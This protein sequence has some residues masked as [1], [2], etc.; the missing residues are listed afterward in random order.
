[1]KRRI[2]CGLKCFSSCMGLHNCNLERRT[3][4]LKLGILMRLWKRCG[5]NYLSDGMQFLR[6]LILWI[7][8]PQNSRKGLMYLL[9]YIKPLYVVDGSDKLCVLFKSYCEVQ[10]VLSVTMSC[11]MVKFWFGPRVAFKLPEFIFVICWI[12]FIWLLFLKM[13]F[14]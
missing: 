3:V 10:Y 1:M 9:Y 14:N 6:R 7:T 8:A 5:S 13:D 12:L 11:R 4:W 2:V